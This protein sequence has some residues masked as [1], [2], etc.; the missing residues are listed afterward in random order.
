M[1][2]LQTLVINDEFLKLPVGTTAQRP[3]NNPGYLRYNTS[4]SRLEGNNGSSWSNQGFIP[5]QATG[6]TVSTITVNGIRYRQHQFNNA[7]GT[8]SVIDA[9]SDAIVDFIM[10]MDG[11]SNSTYDGV[12][13][14]EMTRDKQLFAYTSTNPNSANSAGNTNATTVEGESDPCSPSSNLESLLEYVHTRGARLPTLEEMLND[15][16]QGSGCGSDNVF[17]WVADSF[18][19][20]ENRVAYGRDPSE[21][22]TITTGDKQSASHEARWV[23]DN[24]SNRSDPNVLHH[25]FLYEWLINNGYSASVEIVGPPQVTS[26]VSYDMAL[27]GTPSI[28][29]TGPIDP[30]LGDRQSGRIK[31]RYPLEPPL[32]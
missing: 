22:G 29:N 9:G 14:R 6:G 27:G 31:V 23:A 3:S 24:N 16:T 5:I 28:P 18:S 13:L 10:E 21:R 4:N 20:T 30:G 12:I 19:D 17:Q 7:T 15:V 11:T 25:P 2:N 8:F 32:L 1:A 26:G